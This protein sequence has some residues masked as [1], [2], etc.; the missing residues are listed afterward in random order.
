MEEKLKKL[1]KKISEVS[2]DVTYNKRLIQEKGDKLDELEERVA[3]ILDAIQTLSEEVYE[4][5]EELKIVE[6]EITGIKDLCDDLIEE[7]GE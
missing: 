7:E 6:D 2:F 5:F 1:K 4:C 3:K